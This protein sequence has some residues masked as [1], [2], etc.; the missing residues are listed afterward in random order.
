MSRLTDEER[1]AAAE[2]AKVY[3]R[4]YGFT[5]GVRTVL[6]LVQGWSYDQVLGLIYSGDNLDGVLL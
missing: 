6:G 2:A 4:G 5:Y 3:P 1:L